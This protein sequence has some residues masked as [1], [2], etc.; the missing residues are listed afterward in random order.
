MIR[1]DGLD[2]T[3]EEACSDNGRKKVTFGFSQ[4]SVVI[5]VHLICFLLCLNIKLFNKANSNS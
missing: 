1:D 4:G 2:Y 3:T 5:P